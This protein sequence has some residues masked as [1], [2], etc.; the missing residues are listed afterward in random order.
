MRYEVMTTGD[1][2]ANLYMRLKLSQSQEIMIIAKNHNNDDKYVYISIH[3]IG[4]WPLVIR[5][6][7]LVLNKSSQSW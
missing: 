1:K 5:S 7:F 4:G 2:I 6:C 3:A